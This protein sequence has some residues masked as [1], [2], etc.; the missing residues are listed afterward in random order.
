MSMPP[1]ARLFQEGTARVCQDVANQR[2]VGGQ[3]PLLVGEFGMNTARDPKHGV[4]ESMRAKLQEHPG[5]EAEQARLFEIVLTAAE[6]ER[7]A[8]ILPWCLHD[9]P[10]QNPNESHFGL[11]RADGTLK[12]A[13]L[14]LR[15]TFAR[16]GN[17]DP[18]ADAPPQP[19]QPQ[20][21]RCS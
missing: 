14:V 1:K 13:A 21:E 9:Y 20:P 8:G 11:V 18:V 7:V 3:R 12:P 4:G 6:K 5:T 16:W 17:A 10:I 15:D 2:K 19:G